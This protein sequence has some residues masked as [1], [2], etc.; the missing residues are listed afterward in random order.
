MT[1]QHEY[2]RFILFVGCYVLLNYGYFKIPDALF[3][4]VIHHYGV[5]TIC[6]DLINMLAPME[7]VLAEQSHLISA[8]ADLEIVRG[9][10]GAGVLFLLVAAIV[11]FPSKFKQKVIGLLLGIVFIYLLNL[12][13]IG[14]LYFVMAYHPYWLELIHVYLAPTLMVILA[15]AYFA[16]WAFSSNEKTYEPA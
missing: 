11:A 15:C 12:L 5:V 8:N 3:I 7:K 9:C 1:K 10:D 13:R 14:I 2:L 16:L 6:V 4:N